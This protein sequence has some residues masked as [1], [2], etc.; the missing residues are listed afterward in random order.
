MFTKVAFT[1]LN[2]DF[3]HMCFGNSHCNKLF[4]HLINILCS[5]WHEKCTR[6][7]SSTN[8]NGKYVLT[9]HGLLDH[10]S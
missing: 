6:V 1:S 9:L 3:S 4:I 8:G 7:V 2:G 5:N 10:E